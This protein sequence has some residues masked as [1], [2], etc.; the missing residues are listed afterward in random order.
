[1]L[2]KVFAYYKKVELEKLPE[3]QEGKVPKEV[4]LSKEEKEELVKNLKDSIVN[5]KKTIQL[6][7]SSTVNKNMNKI[8]AGMMYQC[9]Q[10]EWELRMIKS[11]PSGYRVSWP[12]VVANVIN[13]LQDEQLIMILNQKELNPTAL[14]LIGKE[15]QDYLRDYFKIET[16][17]METM[18]QC[19]KSKENMENEMTNIYNTFY[20]VAIHNG[21]EGVRKLYNY[22]KQDF[23][24]RQKALELGVY[25]ESLLNDFITKS[26]YMGTDIIDITKPD[27]EIMK[28]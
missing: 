27:E 6:I 8:T 10:L 26:I 12:S 3:Y 5:L 14:R 15:A 1:M 28:K 17:I 20:N 18:P 16:T 19:R 23:F 11:K 22:G 2:K 9:H 7:A 13:T 24:L 21:K 4:L 25:D